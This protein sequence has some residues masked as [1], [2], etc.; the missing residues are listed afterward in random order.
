MEGAVERRNGENRF[1]GRPGAF[2]PLNVLLLQGQKHNEVPGGARGGSNKVAA[3]DD[4]SDTRPLHVSVR[5]L[6]TTH[7]PRQ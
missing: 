5:L 4:G 7:H 3:G 6:H 1:A 2:K